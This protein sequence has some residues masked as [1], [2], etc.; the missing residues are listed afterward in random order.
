MLLAVSSL[1]GKNLVGRGLDEVGREV[2]LPF[3]AVA[4]GDTAA[5]VGHLGGESL[6]LGL[7]GSLA[8]GLASGGRILE[9]C[10]FFFALLLGDTLKLALAVLLKL[11]D[12][13]CL[14]YTSDA[15]DEL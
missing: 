12:G 7:S 10:G 13:V 4:L 8:F 3:K 6:D 14:L 15:A 2:G 9:V 1:L 11:A 5:V